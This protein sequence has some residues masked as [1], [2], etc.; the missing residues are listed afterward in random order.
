MKHAKRIIALVVAV[1]VFALMIPTAFAA[2]NVK[3]G[4][5]AT[6]NAKFSD[7][8]NVDGTFTLSDPEGIVNGGMTIE[9]GSTGS[10]VGAVQKD[11]IF[12]Y[13]ADGSTRSSLTIKISVPIKSSAQ[14]GDTCTVSFS[15]IK[16]AD[17]PVSS[18]WTITVVK[19]SSSS[20]DDDDEYFS[21]DD[22]YNDDSDDDD[23]EDEFTGYDEYKYG[24][25]EYKLGNRKYILPGQPENLCKA[26]KLEVTY[27]D[28]EEK[29][30]RGEP[31]AFV[32]DADICG[33]IKNISFFGNSFSKHNVKFCFFKWR[34]NLIL[35]YFYSSTVTYHFSA[36]F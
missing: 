30:L 15:G 5:T 2:T 26:E 16:D 4:K 8:V 36:L 24:N 28:Y 33:N 25:V 10:L 3:A 22:N 19:D 1:M 20:D 18:S 29:Q 6:V 12:F 9:A 13:A 14:P 34:C 35:N 27:A 31:L 11:K 21:D 7:V 32:Y 17:V 23:P